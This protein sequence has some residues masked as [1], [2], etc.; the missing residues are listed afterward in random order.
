MGK[1][2]YEGTV[3]TTIEDRLLM[4]LQIV[5]SDKLRRKEAFLFSWLNDPSVGGRTT[6]WINPAASLA[7]RY[8]AKISSTWVN[9]SWLEAL[10]YTA[11]SPGGLH[12]IR[13]PDPLTI[14][15]T[16]VSQRRVDQEI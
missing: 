1:F 7:F 3:K 16:P 12:L 4:H 5:I 10:A 13:E 2:T 15:A 14:A 8:E 9:R 6:V 11:N